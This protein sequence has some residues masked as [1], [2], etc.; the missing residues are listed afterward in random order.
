[1]MQTETCAG[2]G[3]VA[4]GLIVKPEDVCPR[5]AG[6]NLRAERRGAATVR[7]SAQRK[8]DPELQRLVGVAGVARGACTGS[9]IAFAH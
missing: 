5:D 3:P 2:I 8:D 7:G 9:P 4:E 1:M 6:E